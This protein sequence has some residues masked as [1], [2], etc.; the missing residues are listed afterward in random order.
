MDRWRFQSGYADY[1]KQHKDLF[2]TCIGFEKETVSIKHKN[3]SI[4]DHK[5]NDALYRIYNI[6]QIM[7]GNNWQHN[8]EVIYHKHGRNYTCKNQ[9]DPC[10]RYVNLAYQIITVKSI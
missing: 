10:T 5:R 1:I 8:E 6:D 9:C 2:H 7:H 3:I 4:N